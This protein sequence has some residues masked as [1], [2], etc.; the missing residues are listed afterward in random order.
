MH[1]ESRWGAIQAPSPH[2]M[3]WL[4]LPRGAAMRLPRRC[5]GRRNPTKPPTAPAASW[6]LRLCPG[7]TQW[8]EA[9]LLGTELKIP[10]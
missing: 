5:L 9:S 8:G 10:W 6:D 2:P 3:F 7:F 1:Q 4:R